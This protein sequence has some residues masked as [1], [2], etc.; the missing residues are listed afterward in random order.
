MNK[1]TF[2]SSPMNGMQ[3]LRGAPPMDAA[4]LFR[5]RGGG[6]SGRDAGLRLSLASNGHP[7][8]P[9]AEKNVP[10]AASSRLCPAILLLA[11]ERVDS[12]YRFLHL[13]D[14][15]E[16]CDGL[17]KALSNSRGDLP[18][19]AVLIGESVKGRPFIEP[20][21][22]FVPLASVAH[23]QADGRL[24]AMGLALRKN[25]TPKQ[26]RHLFAALERIPKEG[27][28]LGR[29]GTWRIGPHA[30][31]SL[32]KSC[33]SETWTG[34]PKGATDWATVTPVVFEEEMTENAC[35]NMDRSIRLDCRREGLPEPCEVI[36]TPV[37]AHFGAP[38][39][40]VFPCFQNQG[41]KRYHRHAIL[42]FP[43]PVR[44]PV[45]LGA[46]RHDG[47]GLCRPMVETVE[48]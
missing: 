2:P 41:S 34:H 1:N 22:A 16:I 32:P 35:S 5:L 8:P 11:L 19:L 29:F 28:A 47:Y 27:I 4:D 21:V 48:G 12:S 25:T 26:R 40:D 9:P 43:E 37:S 6:H 31:R 17:R 7:T 24:L 44:G 23:P 45:L 42:I 38:P 15:R 33:L 13:L 10:R 39:A 46:G 18:D 20:K 36:V 30:A 14:V 3:L